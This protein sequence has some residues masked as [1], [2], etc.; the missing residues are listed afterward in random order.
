[1]QPANTTTDCR[2]IKMG[3]YA[4][5]QT[6][7]VEWKFYFAVQDSEAITRFG[8]MR[9]LDYDWMLDTFADR[10]EELDE[11]DKER[12]T[13]DLD[14]WRKFVA[15]WVNGN[16]LK[17]LPLAYA[18]EEL[19]DTYWWDQVQPA[20]FWK[21][22]A[23]KAE[24]LAELQSLEE[25]IFEHHLPPWGLA[26][27]RSI[28]HERFND[29]EGKTTEELVSAMLDWLEESPARND[30]SSDWADWMLGMAIWF[31]LESCGDSELTATYEY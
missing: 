29:I 19:G 12:A 17:P 14:R 11:D 4:H 10:L 15:D 8:G 27:R 13:N 25:V 18:E 9:W 2:K 26:D 16:G 3:R 1:M 30:E 24:C 6:T 31:Q 20:H 7:G 23:D 21:G 28:V 5:F 22:E